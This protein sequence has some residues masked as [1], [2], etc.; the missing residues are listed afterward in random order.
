MPDK[1]TYI[2]GRAVIDNND[3]EFC[4]R[5]G[6]PEQ[7]LE[8]ASQQFGAIVSADDAANPQVVVAPATGNVARRA[9]GLGFHWRVPLARPAAPPPV[10]HGNRLPETIGRR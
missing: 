10:A 8:H 7:S 6:L 4:P 3:L 1:G 9:K 5:Q 2:L